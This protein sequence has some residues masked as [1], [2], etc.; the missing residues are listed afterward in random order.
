MSGNTEDTGRDLLNEI[1]DLRRE[2]DEARAEVEKLKAE[3]ARICGLMAI[4]YCERDEAL[5]DAARKTEALE[6]AR[7]AYDTLLDRFDSLQF[8]RDKLLS[9]RDEALADAVRKTEAL[10]DVLESPCGRAHG[11]TCLG[12]VLW[13][14]MESALSD[15]SALDWHRAEVRAAMERVRQ[16][17]AHELYGA[18]PDSWTDEFIKSLD[19]DALAEEKP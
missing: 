5:A 17:I 19:L 12:D 7:R 3:L 10:E 6:V 14:Q 15:T 13:V 1:V 9:E 11:P 16:H 4:A 2:R 8:E 18:R